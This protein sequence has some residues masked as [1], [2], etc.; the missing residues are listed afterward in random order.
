MRKMSS[1]M[2][3]FPVSVPIDLHR[4]FKMKCAAEGTL[5]SEVVRAL[6]ERECSSNSSTSK[7]KAKPVREEIAA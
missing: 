4:R 2:S 1:K 6:L 3:K 7:T 5:M